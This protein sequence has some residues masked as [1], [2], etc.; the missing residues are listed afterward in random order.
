MQL[1]GIL[2]GYLRHND[3]IIPNVGC[4]FFH[5][6]GG[7]SLTWV[8]V[9]REERMGHPQ[10]EATIFLFVLGCATELGLIDRE[11][12]DEIR[13]GNDLNKY[14]MKI[15]LALVNLCRNLG[16]VRYAS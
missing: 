15:G 6:Y 3:C 10:R 7:T 14:A 4:R 13:R 1:R 2:V 12:L 9:C 11:D 16:E 8:I 5:D